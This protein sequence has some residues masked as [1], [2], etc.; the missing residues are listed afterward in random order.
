MSAKEIDKKKLIELR[1]KL[2]E[3]Q[4]ELQSKMVE[5][6]DG[7]RKKT[8]RSILYIFVMLSVLGAILIG[9]LL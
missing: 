1:D 2:L 4:N 5:S 3:L 6:C 8:D 7:V 9:V